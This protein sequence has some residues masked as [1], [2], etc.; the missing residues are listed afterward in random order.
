MHENKSC[1]NLSVFRKWHET[2]GGNDRE[3]RHSRTSTKKAKSNQR[4]KS[5][6]QKQKASIRPCGRCASEVSRGFSIAALAHRQQTGTT[7]PHTPLQS[8]RPAAMVSLNALTHS[9]FTA[10]LH[11]TQGTQKQNKDTHACTRTV[12]DTNIHA[13]KITAAAQAAFHLHT[14]SFVRPEAMKFT[15]KHREG[16]TTRQP[17]QHKKKHTAPR[18]F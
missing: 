3:K 1:T 18:G 17:R 13:W 11:L 15:Q 5:K 10:P 7:R 4:S 16:R 12:P 14:K 8:A 6:P 9:F 2:Q